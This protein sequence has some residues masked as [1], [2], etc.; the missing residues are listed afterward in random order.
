MTSQVSPCQ[1][2]LLTGRG[3]F[4]TP[5]TF[6]DEVSKT[7]VRFL[8]WAG[9]LLA[10]CAM[11]LFA[12]VGSSGTIVGV[13][14]DNSGAVLV[15]A[16]ITATDT[17]TTEKRATS[18]NTAGRYVFA[19]LPPATYEITVTQPGFKAVKIRQDVNVGSVATTNISLEVGAVSTVVEVQASGAQLQTMNATIGTTMNFDMAQALPGLSR[20]VSG[21]ALLQPATTPVNG[22]AGQAGSV[23]GSNADQNMFVLDG[24]NNSSDMDGTN[25]VYL[26]GFAGNPI[27]G[28]GSAVPNGVVPTPI[29][30]I[31]EFKVGIAGQTADFNSAAGSQVTMATRRGTNTWHGTG[32]EYYYGTNFSA[33]SW[34]NGHTPSTDP[35]TGGTRGFTPLPSRH[36]NR[37]GAS[38]GGPVLPFNFLGGK[39]YIFGFY[40]GVRFPNIT[41]LEKSTPSPLL[42]AGVI[43][44][45]NSSSNPITLNGVS[46]APNAWMPFNLN[47]NPVTVNGVTY[48]PANVC[49]S[50]GNQPCDPRGIGINPIVN[51]IWSQFM[52]V[53]NDLAPTSTVGDSFNTIGYRNTIRL[54][55]SDNNWVVRL[56]HDFAKNW[57]FM[58][59]YRYYKLSQA[60]LA[61]ADVGGILGGTK[62]Q[63][64]STRNLP[65]YPSILVFGLNTTIGS[66]LTND[67]HYSYTYNWWQWGD[68]GAPPQPIAG[69]GGAVEIGGETTA[70]GGGRNALIPYNVNTQDVR[71]RFWDG[72]DH[73]F[74]DDLNLLKGNHLFQ[75]GGLYQRNFD[76]HDRN[77]NGQ[78]TMAA[79][80]Y[81][82]TDGAGISWSGFLPPTSIVPSSQQS[83]FQTLV[84]DV[85]GIVSQPQT[86]YTRAGSDL[87]LLPLGTHAQDKSIIPYYQGYWS[88]TWHMKPSFTVTYGLSYAVEMPPYETSGKQVMLTDQGGNAIRMTDYLAQRKSAALAGQVYN[89]VLGFALVNN[90]TGGRK[91]PYDPFYKGISPRASA[92]WNPHFTSGILGSLLGDGKSVIR[93]GYSRIYGRLN[94]V[95]QV[96]VPLLGT[97][98]MQAVACV[99]A[100]SNGQCLG[101]GGVNP[102]TAFRIGTDGLVAPLGG[103]PSSTLAQPYLPG[104]NGNLAAAPG[105][106][107]D[108]DTRPSVN[109]SFT[110]SI[111]RE[112]SSKLFVEAGY[113]GKIINN[114]FQEINVDAIPYMTTLGGQTFANAYASMYTA[115]CGLNV[116]VCP[117]ANVTTPTPQPFVEQALGGPTSNFCKAAA[118]CTAA[119]IAAQRSLIASNRVYELWN[120]MATSTSWTLGRTNPGMNPPGGCAANVIVCRQFQAFEFDTSNGYGNYNGLF[121]TATFRDWH[122]IT[123]R[124]NFTWGRSFGTGGEVQARSTRTVLDPWNL[125]SEY[126]PNGF[127][128]KFIYNMALNYQPSFYKTQ[129]GILGHLLGGW[130]I[131][132]LFTAQS[133]FPLNVVQQDGSGTST[134]R[135][136][137]GQ[138]DPSQSSIYNVV[139]TNGSFNGGNSLNYFKTSPTGTVG[140]TATSKGAT[141]TSTEW[142]N[143]FGDPTAAYGQFRRLILGVDE[144]G[145]GFGIL[146]GFPRWN[147]DMTVT[148]DIRATERV[149][150]TFTA[151]MT[152][153]LNH[154][155]PDDPS[156]N[157]NSPATF[158]RVSAQATGYDSRQ[159]EFG[160]RLRW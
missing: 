125:E 34:A 83:N 84:A 74:R 38:A 50:G 104:V 27:T 41:T 86:L 21:L 114:E 23:A 3:V 69:L 115:I 45:Q 109:D 130:S 13:V 43:Q 121:A 5:V 89:P 10:L 26:S 54:P 136:A 118:S 22:T 60:D 103:A 128:V 20:D 79:N 144:R 153:V 17:T 15:G 28:G 124:S 67:F 119:L 77:D 82:V 56:D 98:I 126:G 24:G 80:V 110:L 53:G 19:N 105:S 140:T 111:Q 75:F 81:Q 129:Q 106:G 48:Q 100:S 138:S 131:S 152:N 59:S 146:R 65:S 1:R 90:V 160:L 55:Q 151:M 11:P 64:T 158:G 63:Y 8:A 44:I 91:Y 135:E 16:N 134:S 132:P 120:A 94:G 2:P 70:A 40:Q 18:T 150:L 57:H 4:Y 139:L 113:I 108:P 32:Y 58:G 156:M 51:Q 46:F 49:G 157:L 148:K 73:M 39:T 127:D 159:I 107:L 145:N 123:A 25:T 9:F 93:G 117:A 42:R 36:Q 122:G 97:G 101:T 149:G 30:S 143:M 6:K 33:N 88:D 62:G 35:A 72:Q 7:I 76:W 99:G 37:F 137:F 14:T 87:H 61:Q 68:A 92:A 52:P 71:T 141:G 95:N 47:P 96:L 142:L 85:L 133:G 112:V 155:Q 31:E 116:Q 147:L 154:F 78:G 102:S 29:E 66:N 12:Q